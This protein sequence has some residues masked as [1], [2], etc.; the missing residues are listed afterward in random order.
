MSDQEHDHAAE[1]FNAELARKSTIQR[2]VNQ[3]VKSLPVQPQADFPR[4]EVV[5]HLISKL[6]EKVELHL[7]DRD[8]LIGRSKANGEPADLTPIVQ[9]ELLLSKYIDPNSV[10]TAISEGK[11]AIA[12][13]S[14]FKT[15]GEKIAFQRKYGNDFYD[16]LPL[17]R[18]PTFDRTDL[19][20]MTAAQYDD[21]TVPEK[22]KLI[23]EG[24]LNAT[25]IYEISRR[26]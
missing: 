12:A 2:R 17:H 23:S 20:H 9:D 1:S 5:N 3:I 18:A 16:R 6:E 24:K 4:E 26:K 11:L 7:S 14:D 25:K 22:S 19:D 8:W 21:L 15:L 10:S 13:K